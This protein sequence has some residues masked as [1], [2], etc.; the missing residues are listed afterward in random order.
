[1]AAVKIKIYAKSELA[2]LYGVQWRTLKKMILPDVKISEK[3]RLL[4]VNEVEKIVAVM[5]NP[6]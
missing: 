4:T 3:R 5:G 2:T 1:M 6:E